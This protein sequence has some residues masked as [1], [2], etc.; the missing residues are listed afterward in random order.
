MLLPC[1]NGVND[2]M[3]HEQTVE[4]DCHVE[5]YAMEVCYFILALLLHAIAINVICTLI[6]HGIR[7]VQWRTL[8]PHGIKFKTQLRENGQLVKGYDIDGRVDRIISAIRRFELMGKMQIGLGV[9][10]LV[11]YFVTTIVVIVQ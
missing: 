1:A 5:L 10:L 8:C 3:I 6:F 2:E 11:V 7:Q 9:T 4:A